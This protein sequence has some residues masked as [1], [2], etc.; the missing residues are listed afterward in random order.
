MAMKMNNL[1][2]GKSGDFM[3]PSLAIKPLTINYSHDILT[4]YNRNIFATEKKIKIPSWVLM[5]VDIRLLAKLIF[6]C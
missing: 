2:A 1:F 5:I 4:N 3:S 6:M